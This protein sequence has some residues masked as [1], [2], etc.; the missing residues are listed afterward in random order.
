M[1]HTILNFYEPHPFKRQ[2]DYYKI[3]QYDI[4]KSIGISQGSLSKML[5]GIA[6]MRE[7]VETE[8][9]AIL[10][11]VKAKKKKPKKIVKRGK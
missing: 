5:N 10:N 11:Y 4:A 3:K 6:P 8:I 2:I 9:E 1:N 7:I